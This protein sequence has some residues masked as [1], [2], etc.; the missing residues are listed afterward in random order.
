MFSFLFKINKLSLSNKIKNNM[1][2]CWKITKNEK[3]L[4]NQIYKT[5]L[6]KESFEHITFV[7]QVWLTNETN[8]I[9]IVKKNNNWTYLLIDKNQNSDS[10]NAIFNVNQLLN[11]IN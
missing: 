6:Y 2:T 5:F 8:E 4:M 3:N 7:F 11:A 9:L 1:E 10:D